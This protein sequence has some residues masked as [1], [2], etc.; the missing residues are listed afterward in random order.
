MDDC[1]PGFRFDAERLRRV[2]VLKLLQ[3]GTLPA[4]RLPYVSGSSCK[5]YGSKIRSKD[6]CSPK[7]RILVWDFLL[8]FSSRS[9]SNSFSIA[10]D[11]FLAS[12]S[13]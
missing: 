12:L 7:I 9:L 5:P 6:G 10:C 13:C 1:S 8:C 3:D 4:L 11:T 2:E